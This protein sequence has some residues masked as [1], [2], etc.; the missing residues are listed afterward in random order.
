MDASLSLCLAAQPRVEELVIQQGL[1]W[2]HASK[3][4][5]EGEID[6]AGEE[7]G[8]KGPE[9]SIFNR[10]S[11]RGARWGWLWW[12]RQDLSVGACAPKLTQRCSM[13]AMIT[14]TD[15]K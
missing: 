1:P 4:E 11:C 12:D 14:V 7:L 3:D 15:G 5:N 10:P 6:E 9:K 13:P 8:E 2:S